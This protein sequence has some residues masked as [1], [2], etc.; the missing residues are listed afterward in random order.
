MYC[1]Y[2]WH[3]RRVAVVYGIATE[4]A[5]GHLIPLHGRVA[6]GDVGLQN[7]A[8]T[9]QCFMDHVLRGFDFCYV[10]IDDLLVASSS[11]EEHK[12]HL[13]Q[14]FERLRHYGI[15]INPQK[16]VFGASSVEFLG[17]FVDSNGIHPLPAKVQAIVDFPRPTSCR[18]L[19][20]FLGLINFIITSYLDT[21]LS[22]GNEYISWDDTAIQSFSGGLKSVLIWWNRPLS[23]KSCC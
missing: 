15:I 18:Q 19:R 2:H 17:H 16:C 9:F 4:T 21:L 22:G 8:Q 12:Q 14:I 13:R 3:G 10:Y 5:Y 7:A 11:P 20:T 6:A 23:T 1:Q